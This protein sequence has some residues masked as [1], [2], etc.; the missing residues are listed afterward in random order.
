MD[1]KS[2]KNLWLEPYRLFFA[3]GS[4]YAFLAVGLW[5]TWLHLSDHSIHWFDFREGPAQ[6]HSHVML[7]G[8]LGFYIFG[9]ILTAFPRFIG[10]DHPKKTQVVAWFGGLV[11][12]QICFFLGA[13]RDTA[14]MVLAGM[15][16][17]SCYLSLLYFLG[18]LYLRS[19]KWR[20]DRQPIF[21]LLALGLGTLGL[22]LS[23]IYYALYGSFTFYNLS[24]ELGTYGYL[25]LMVVGITY[26]I[27]P[28]FA[29]RVIQNYAGSRG[30]YTLTLVTA[31]VLL[32]IFL[33]TLWADSPR[34]HYVSWTI[35]IALLAIL[36]SEWGRWKPWQAKETPILFVLFLGLSWILIFLGFSGYELAFHLLHS[37]A[38]VYPILRTP[39]LHALYIG[40]FGTL[41]LAISTR[42]V[43]GHGGVPIVADRFTLTAL[44]LLQLAAVWRVFIPI[45]FGSS[46]SFWLRNYWAGL[47]WCIAF[48]V[49]ALRYFPLLLRPKV[50]EAG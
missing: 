40:A 25:F 41:V 21:L 16:E 22:G 1:R 12:A 11:S 28:F 4:L 23:Y 38:E 18:M 45:L 14:W 17:L 9:F 24:I 39:A 15:L 35:N 31:L 33:V 30:P 8:V 36:A 50:A 5:F 37:N 26:R 2:L 13:T 32:R 29:G 46:G 20:S 44:L 6:Y 7:F 3:G 42:V 43:R 34:Q 19:G 49:W 27:V 10:Q 48:A 47:F